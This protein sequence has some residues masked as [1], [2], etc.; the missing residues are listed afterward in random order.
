MEQYELDISWCDSSHLVLGPLYL[1]VFAGLILGLTTIFTPVFII[2]VRQSIFERRSGVFCIFGSLIAYFVCLF[3][4]IF[5][6]QNFLEIWSYAE[7]F[8]T[9]YSWLLIGRYCTSLST[10]TRSTGLRLSFFTF[11]TPLLPYL[12][13]HAWNGP[14]S[15]SIARLPMFRVPHEPKKLSLFEIISNFSEV[16]FGVSPLKSLKKKKDQLNG[17]LNGFQKELKTTINLWDR[18]FIEAPELKSSSQISPNLRENINFL[19]KKVRNFSLSSKLKNFINKE[20]T[21]PFSL[22]H[23]FPYPKNL[24]EPETNPNLKTQIGRAAQREYIKRQNYDMRYARP[25]TGS[26]YLQGYGGLYNLEF[27]RFSEPRSEQDEVQFFLFGFCLVLGNQHCP[28]AFLNLM[29]AFQ[30]DNLISQLIFLIVAISIF[31]I[32]TLLQFFICREF[33]KKKYLEKIMKIGSLKR[34]PETRLTSIID[35]FFVP[36]LILFGLLPLWGYTNRG[37]SL[38]SN[39]TMRLQLGLFKVFKPMI[40]K[41]QYE[42]TLADKISLLHYLP[43]WYRLDQY[44]NGYDFFETDESA[45]N[46]R[47][48]DNMQD[49]S[50]FGDN[51]S[52]TVYRNSYNVEGI[53]RYKFIVRKMLKQ[54]PI[55]KKLSALAVKEIEKDSIHQILPSF[56]RFA[57]ENFGIYNETN[58][59][60]PYELS[61]RGFYDE[62]KQKFKYLQFNAVYPFEYSTQNEELFRFMFPIDSSGYLNVVPKDEISAELRPGVYQHF[63]NTINLLNRLNYKTLMTYEPAQK[64]VPLKTYPFNTKE[65]DLDLIEFDEEDFSDVPLKKKTKTK[66]NNSTE[67]HLLFQLDSNSLVNKPLSQNPKLEL[68]SEIRSDSFNLIE[69]FELDDYV[70]K[71]HQLPYIDNNFVNTTPNTINNKTGMMDYHLSKIPYFLWSVT[72]EEN[73]SENSLSNFIDSSSLPNLLNKNNQ[74]GEKYFSV[75]EFRP[76][77]KDELIKLVSELNDYARIIEAS[78]LLHPTNELYTEE[79]LYP[80]IYNRDPMNKF[81]KFEVKPKKSSLDR[82]EFNKSKPDLLNFNKVSTD[83]RWLKEK[84]H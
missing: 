15:N 65:L 61:L 62:L 69:S 73:I 52:R 80:E 41:S 14:N 37:L 13:K 59:S 43:N 42:K 33:M 54:G 60:Y 53:G 1:G 7:P 29:Y 46:D 75:V 36:V 58:V 45:N 3:L 26:E 23:N 81:T 2:S 74:R 4:F 28:G 5:G 17:K 49:M 51:R 63:F 27:K 10:F 76:T 79:F 66:V 82:L 35:P 32:L 68:L 40:G 25:F 11:K 6:S 50:V 20:Q 38:L 84:N 78:F 67:Q 9:V 34:L 31:S 64:K 16:F 71:N 22:S 30:S 72:E 39:E 56:T 57:K 55:D 24:R 48:D 21:Y 83:H 8:L 44:D 12:K 18:N 19:E 70:K 77:P 47:F